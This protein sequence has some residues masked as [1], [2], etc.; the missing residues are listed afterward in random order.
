MKFDEKLCD[1]LKRLVGK[2]AG[3]TAPGADFKEICEYLQVAKMYY[4]VDLGEE[5]R[6]VNHR[7]KE[8]VL[9]GKKESNK[10]VLFDNSKKTD[11]LLKYTYY[12]ENELEYV[13]A[14]IEFE[15]GI[16]REE[17]DEELFQFM[18]DMVYLLVSRQNMRVMLDFAEVTDAQTGI[19]NV[20]FIRRQ[21]EKITKVIPP[22]ELAVLFFNLQNFR[23]INEVAGA[24]SG[25]EAL[26]QYARILMGFVGE[27]ESV[28]RLGGDNFV[29]FV[30]NENL[31]AMLAKLKAVRIENLTSAP[32]SCFEVSAWV[33]I[34]DGKG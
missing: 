2:A 9:P 3:D 16:R 34:S 25:D 1:I 17:L 7:T 31:D 26:I 33:G 11:L 32:S 8:L 6:Y 19:P 5:G 23:Y 18:A 22:G 20:V 4:D 30:R 10:I 13:H 12:Y 14:Y 29:M 28:C 15:E 21:F 27:Y 24:K